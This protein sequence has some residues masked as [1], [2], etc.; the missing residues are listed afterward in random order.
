MAVLAKTRNFPGDVNL[1][2]VHAPSSESKKMCITMDC[3]ASLPLSRTCVF[4]ESRAKIASGSMPATEAE[5]RS[6]TA[7]GRFD[8]VFWRSFLRIPIMSTITPRLSLPMR[9]MVKSSTTLSCKTIFEIIDSFSNERSSKNISS[10]GSPDTYSTC[11]MSFRP[12]G[13]SPSLPTKALIFAVTLRSVPSMRSSGAT[14]SRSIVRARSDVRKAI[15]KMMKADIAISVSASARAELTKLKY[16]AALSG[17]LHPSR[18]ARQVATT[19]FTM[20]CT[21]TGVCSACRGNEPA[22]RMRAERPPTS[23]CSG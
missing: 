6:L 3:C 19:C 22:P 4:Q 21:R 14:T 9:S 10:S 1:D 13:S 2:A 8:L 5:N 18:V 23:T 17:P 11:W 15:T 16:S 12:P 20:F 7:S